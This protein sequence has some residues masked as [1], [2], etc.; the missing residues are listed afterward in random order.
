MFARTQKFYILFISICMLFGF[1]NVFSQFPDLTEY[2][3]YS[4]YANV[5]LTGV[6]EN[7]SYLNGEYEFSVDSNAFAYFQAISNSDPLYGG[8]RFFRL[9][10]KEIYGV[11]NEPNETEGE[12]VQRLEIIM[13]EGWNNINHFEVYKYDKRYNTNNRAL[14]K[15]ITQNAWGDYVPFFNS[16]KY[17]FN[18]IEYLSLNYKL[19][20]E[21]CFNAILAAQY[22]SKQ[23]N[24]D[25]DIVYLTTLEEFFEEGGTIN[26][27]ITMKKVTVED[28][29]PP[30]KP[31]DKYTGLGRSVGN[32]NKGISVIGV[33][34]EVS[35]Y[36]ED[37]DDPIELLGGETLYPSDRI[38]TGAESSVLIKGPDGS[39]ILVKELTDVRMSTFENDLSGLKTRLWLK[40]GE[41]D[42]EINHESSI[43]SDFS[44]KTPTA[45][46]GVRGTKFTVEYDSLLNTTDVFTVDGTVYISNE[47]YDSIE[48][49]GVDYQL[50]S[51]ELNAWE[52]VRI[53]DHDIGEVQPITFHGLEINPEV[54]HLKPHGFFVFTPLAILDEDGSKIP[55]LAEWETSGGGE[56]YDNGIFVSNGEFGVFPISCY[57]AT[58]GMEAT[59]LV[60]VDF[61]YPDTTNTLLVSSDPVVSPGD[62]LWLSLFLGSEYNELEGV[63]LLHFDL[64]IN[65]PEFLQLFAPENASFQ[66]SDWAADV[67]NM[68]YDYLEDKQTFTFDL[69]QLNENSL[70]SGSGELMKVGFVA[71]PLGPP[72]HEMEFSIS[73]VIL[74]DTSNYRFVIETN[75]SVS[76]IADRVGLPEIIADEYLFRDSIEVLLSA[77]EGAEVYYTLNGLT[78]T[79]EDALYTQPIVF[80]TSQLLKVRAFKEGFMPSYPREASFVIDDSPEPTV[81]VAQPVSTALCEGGRA[82]FNIEASGENLSYQWQKDEQNIEGAIEAVYS[83]DAVSLS[84]Q[85]EYGCIV[86]GDQGEVLSETAY[87]E[88]YEKL[89]IIQQPLPADLKL[90]AEA[91]FT[92]EATGD[93]LAYQWWKDEVLLMDND[94]ISGTETAELTINSVDFS[95]EGFYNCVVTGVCNDLTSEEVALSINTRVMGFIQAGFS[96]QPNPAKNYIFLKLKGAIPGRLLIYNEEGQLVLVKEYGFRQIDVGHLPPGKYYLHLFVEDKQVIGEFLKL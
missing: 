15:E 50:D 59:A 28:D 42:A 82:E 56:I 38:Y 44:V 6:G 20:G 40:N 72:L 14:N 46:C 49:A 51:I 66:L 90:G 34:G 73:D 26:I 78:P 79:E 75:K 95:D 16:N 32:P 8:D 71:D 67:F 91:N 33:E 68:D 21:S 47:G 39:S 37:N 92:I 12:R 19:T 18:N 69:T 48:V 85:G 93:I 80:D 1:Q 5:Y 64:D 63:D 76:V 74:Q 7:H 65:H 25:G 27:R 3:F 36:R 54:I 94:R 83:I 10:G 13:D 88:V 9:I 96:I 58:S 45:I 31:S 41:I 4:A 70:L 43:R 23:Y 57:E 17:T 55:V 60:R 62:T 77:L 11:S 35:I 29:Q 61:P 81:I 24:A 52:R 2:E 22:E 53:N 84:D 87:L 89:S 86:S 30:D